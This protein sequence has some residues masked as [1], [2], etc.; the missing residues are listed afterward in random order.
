MSTKLTERMFLT[1]KRKLTQ[2][3]AKGHGESNARN[4]AE[5]QEKVNLDK[6]KEYKIHYTGSETA[7]WRW[8]GY[9]SRMNDNR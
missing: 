7:D 6:R 1:K 5:R 4:N 9:V 3:S 2:N 8:A